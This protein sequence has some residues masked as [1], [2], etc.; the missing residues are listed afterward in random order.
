M[1]YATWRRVIPGFSQSFFLRNHVALLHGDVG[2]PRKADVM[3][4]R[5][6][7][8]DRYREPTHAHSVNPMGRR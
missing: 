5:D 3:A 2:H 4:A 1:T 7:K 8:Q 6:Q